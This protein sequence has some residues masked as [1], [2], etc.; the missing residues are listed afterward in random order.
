MARE[1]KGLA[2][3]IGVG[4]AKDRA[5]EIVSRRVLFLPKDQA[6]AGDRVRETDLAWEIDPV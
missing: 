2:S 4:P 6:Q 1:A 3:E 5:R